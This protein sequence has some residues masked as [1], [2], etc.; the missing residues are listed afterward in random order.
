MIWIVAK[1]VQLALKEYRCKSTPKSKTV[2]PCLAV[3]QLL[4]RFV[5][6]RACREIPDFVA[7][8]NNTGADKPVHLHNLVSGIVF[9]FFCYLLSMITY[10]MHTFSVLPAKSVSD[11]MF[12][13]QN[14]EGL[15]IVSKI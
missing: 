4:S 14:Y 11:V 10:N 9:F 2:F 7:Y 1:F 6:Y 3:C 5:Y 12:C 13:L 8:A 15:I